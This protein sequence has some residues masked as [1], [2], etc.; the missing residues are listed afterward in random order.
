MALGRG[1]LKL[2]TLKNGGG[3]FNV[4]ASAVS[5]PVL[6]PEHTG[7]VVLS[8]GGIWVWNGAAWT[9]PGAPSLAEY[10][11]GTASAS[12]PNARL[13]V[14]TVSIGW[15]VTTPAQFKADLVEPSLVSL[16]SVDGGPGLPYLTAGSTWATLALA[17][18]KGI[19]AT[20]AGA[21]AT[22]DLTAKARTVLDDATYAAMRN[23]MGGYADPTLMNTAW[24]SCQ[25]N[26]LNGIN[27][28][29]NNNG[30]SSVLDADG[31]FRR[32]TT[33]SVS[34]NSQY[35]GFTQ[36]GEIFPAANARTSFTFRADST[37]FTTN[38]RFWIGLTTGVP[39]DAATYASQSNVILRYSPTDGDTRFR[40]FTNNGGASPVL[41][42]EFGPVIANNGLY[43]ITFQWSTPTSCTIT[44]EDLVNNTTASTVVATAVMPTVSIFGTVILYTKSADA[45]SFDLGGIALQRPFKGIG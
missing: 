28:T 3:V 21:I 36:G 35:L 41:G 27:C 37:R 31:Y 22:Y 5:P 11:L 1:F 20:G 23:T 9:A 16:L 15:D 12:L 42:D 4:Y 43:R 18:D 14:N 26:Q 39:P 13:P 2:L 29:P 33:G 10:F 30:T 40:P 44:V 8:A 24:V 45:R 38:Q 6:T 7:D 25:A 17:A 32:F 34:G 19:Y